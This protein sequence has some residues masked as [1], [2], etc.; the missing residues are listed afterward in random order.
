MA[1][2]GTYENGKKYIMKGSRWVLVKSVLFQ[3][4]VNEAILK[5]R[6]FPTLN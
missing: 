1:I 4:V 3:L 5:P 6:V 2:D